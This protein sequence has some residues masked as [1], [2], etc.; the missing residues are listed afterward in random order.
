MPRATVTTEAIRVDLKSCPPDGYVEL[1]QLPYHEMLVRR[2]RG[3]QLFFD[4]TGEEQK[5]EIATLQAWARA[6]EFEHCIVDHNLEDE[7]GKKLDFSKEGVLSVLDPRVGQEI[8]EHIDKLHNVE[9]DVKD[10]PS[11]A[12]SSLEEIVP[13]LNESL[14]KS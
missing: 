5:V 14:V 13:D 10:F 1:R 4:P 6:Y 2:D 7:H 11:P 8:E 3:G 12:S 9:Q